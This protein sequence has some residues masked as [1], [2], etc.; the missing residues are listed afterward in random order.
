ML[1]IIRCC[2]GSTGERLRDEEKLLNALATSSQEQDNT[3]SD[4]N[5]GDGTSDGNED[6][7][8]DGGTGGGN[9]D[10]GTSGGNKTPCR[11]CVLN[12]CPTEE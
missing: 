2:S 5:D 12:G 4:G 3:S 11:D 6:Y 9:N 8:A 7:P 10:G 1:V